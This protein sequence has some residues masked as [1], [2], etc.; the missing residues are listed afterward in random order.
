MKIYIDGQFFDRDDARVSVFD[1][2]LLYGDGVF[3]GIR[4]YGGRVFKLDEHIRRLYDSARAIMLDI[5]LEPADMARAVEDTVAINS[6]TGGYIRLVITRGAGDLGL[7]PKSCPRPSVIIIASG[8]HVYPAEYYDKGIE[9]VTVATRRVPNESLDSRVKSLNYLN[10]VLAK[11]EASRSGCLEAVMLNTNGYVAE[12]TADNIFVVRDGA[13]K[14]PPAYHG[15]LDGIT[16]RAVLELARAKGMD[17]G[18]SPLTRYD[19][20]TAAECFLTGTGAEIMPV[21]RVD[22]R[23]VGEG[24]PGPVTRLLD[25][26]FRDMVL[27]AKAVKSGDKG[28]K[29]YP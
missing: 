12:C 18:H 4:V 16:M 5:P 19:L 11:M 10:N 24:S 8:I 7:D 27:S 28:C 21:V 3:E 13:I 14:T 9:V 20:Y 17:A 23:D 15:A 22:G 6:I 26:A 1:H 2:G 25:E 29:R